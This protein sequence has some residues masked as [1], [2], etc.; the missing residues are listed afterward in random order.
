MEA[1]V[2]EYGAQA[3]GQGVRYRDRGGGVHRQCLA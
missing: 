1:D 3:N 2:G